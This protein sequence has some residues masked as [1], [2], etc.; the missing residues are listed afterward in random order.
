MTWPWSRSY[1]QILDCIQIN[2][3]KLDFQR[4]VIVDWYTLQ[5]VSPNLSWAIIQ[6]NKKRISFKLGM[7]SVYIEF[8]HDTRN[9][10][11]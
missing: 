7:I 9:I 2:V 3:I 11:V 10:H 8:D 4:R 1:P 5:F 6:H